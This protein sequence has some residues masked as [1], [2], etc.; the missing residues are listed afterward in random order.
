[1]RDGQNEPQTSRRRR[2]MEKKQEKRMEIFSWIRMFVIVVVV[3]FV[4]TRFIIINATVPSGSM[5]T[6]IMTKDRLIGFRFSYWFDEPDRGDIILFSYPVDESQ[7]YIKRVI[8]LP[9]ET[10]E[11]RDGG[12]YID[13]SDTP[14]QEDYLPEEWYWENDG[15]YFE[16]PED[17][18]FVLGDN[19]NNSL[20][21]RFWAR[22]AIS[23]GIAESE[24]DA[25]SYSF[26]RED[27]IKGKAIFTYY[28]SFKLLINTADYGSE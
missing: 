20:D 22:E 21:G 7:T 14:L 9:G 2:D 16:V 4:A 3:V 24:E 5:E 18:Y 6:T 8:G 26:V 19:R 12:I 17:C 28:S 10:V 1:M 15:Y 27:Q 25:L 13:G 23:A 11:I